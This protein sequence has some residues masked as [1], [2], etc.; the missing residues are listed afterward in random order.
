M[1]KIFI[2]LV[3]SLMAISCKKESNESQ[4]A[5]ATPQLMEVTFHGDIFAQHR[6]V[7]VNGVE[8]DNHTSNVKTGDVIY[9]HAWNSGCS[10]TPG[11]SIPNCSQAEVKLSLDGVHRTKESCNCE[12]LEY[13]FVID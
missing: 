9:M 11:S 10:Y 5:D 6:T 12:E 1:K 13:E 2:V 3:V 7:K 4:S 8:I